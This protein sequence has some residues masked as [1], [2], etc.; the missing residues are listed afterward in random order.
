MM[1]TQ[2]WRVLVID[3]NPEMTADA[4]REL[5][6]AF[7]DND[8]INITVCVE[9][10]FEVGYDKVRQGTCDIVVLDVR[11]DATATVA[12]DRDAGRRI[13]SEVR[14]VRFLPVIFW[15]ALPQEVQDQEMPPLVRVFSKTDLDQI[16]D[17]ICA[18]IDSDSVRVMTGIENN[19]TQI[20][21]QHMWDELA[22]NWEEDTVGGQPE[23]L[24][25]ILITRVA[26]SLQDQ[27]LP[28]LTSR[29]SHCYLYP[30][31]SAKYRP[32][33]ILRTSGSHHF[34]WW[35]ILTPACDLEHRGKAQFA[36]LGRANNLLT[37]P[38]YVDWISTKSKEK[39]NWNNLKQVLAGAVPRYHYLPKFRELPDLILDLEDLRS[40]PIAELG[41]FTRMASLVGPYS[42]SLLVKQSHF[43]G[44][45]GVPDLNSA[46][47][48]DRL[49]QARVVGDENASSAASAPGCA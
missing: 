16:P 13:F 12:E 43:R 15:T 30:P 22:P 5:V 2:T 9:N 26:Q 8:E 23:E 21:R 27:A 20:M 41:S 19:V 7:E 40:V 47:V 11:R 29:P 33:D 34:E 39:E 24:A 4:Q 37:F 44:R 32:G 38:K 35:V 25:R 45:I 18:A 17:A 14:D 48:K 6:E 1:S 42:E 3:D 10:D 36:L 49:S 28:E 46:A 31:V